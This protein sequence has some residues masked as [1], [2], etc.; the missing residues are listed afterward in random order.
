M[1]A[2]LLVALTI[3]A[4][5]DE[6]VVYPQTIVVSE[7]RPAL[8]LVRSRDR[9]GREA[10]LTDS[11]EISIADPKIARLD[12]GRVL[13]VSGGETRLIV[14]NESQ[15]LEVPVIVEPLQANRGVSFRADVIPVLTK[16]GCN[17]GTCH[18]AASG[19]D[20]FSLSLFGYDPNGDYRAITRHWVGRRVNRSIPQESLLLKKATGTVPH[21]GGRKI[22]PDSLEY[23]TLARWIEEGAKDD[24]NLPAKV[25]QLDLYPQEITLKPGQNQRLVV[26]ARRADGTQHDV[27]RWA[28]FQSTH[29]Q[30]AG[31]RDEGVAEAESQGETFITAR[32]DT[33][34]T[35]RSVIVQSADGLVDWVGKAQHNK[36]DEL[37]DRKLQRRGISPAPLCDDGTFIRRLSLDLRGRLPSEEE[38]KRFT[39]NL[40]KAKRIELIDDYLESESFIDLATMR[41]SEV[42]KVRS[43]GKLSR[44]GVHRY[45][46]WLRDQIENN[47]PLD[48]WVHQLISSRGETTSNPAGYFFQTEKEVAKQAENIAQIFLGMRLQCA[49]CHNHPFDRWTMDDYYG[50][51]AFLAQVGRKQGEDPREII[52]FHQ[53]TGSV[54]HPVSGEEVTPQY[55]GGDRPELRERDPRAVLAEWITDSANPYFAPHMANTLWSWV[56][57]RGIVDEVDDVRVSNPP[58]NAPLLEYLAGQLQRNKFDARALLRD[59]CASRTYQ[60][61]VLTNPQAAD[62]FAGQSLRPLSA[63]V[64][65]DAIAQV[66]GAPSSFEKT[67]AGTTA[68]QLTDG[69]VTNN[70]LK[71]FGRSGRLTVCTCETK[72]EPTLSQALHLV[73]GNTVHQKISDGKLVK[74][75]LDNDLAP[76]QIIDKLFMRCLSREASST[77]RAAIRG[78]L[79]DRSSQEVLEDLFW[80]LMN[81]P[82]FSFNH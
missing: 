44:Q 48:R 49:S 45:S 79:N 75:W 52:L 76:D 74:Q 18:G 70:F 43:G 19:Q 15:R 17:S 46:E 69:A 5:S 7:S 8:F 80:S 27:T 77:E 13:P 2:F 59:I 34:T 1:N 28:E 30:T 26:V 22:D 21:T 36:I 38:V 32:F 68:V 65:H 29:P 73:N 72:N 64:L 58:V 81:S 54:R 53:G 4:A 61:E 24:E 40:N 66:T 42:L 16:S 23:E 71:T 9:D 78:Q 12:G 51:A 35:G 41:W 6:I 39:A 56:F 62:L 3:G 10:E 47:I 67:I 14:K 55:L 31:V 63:P 33:L 50:F 25:I 57:H 60:A 11:C 20:G 82:E 37:V